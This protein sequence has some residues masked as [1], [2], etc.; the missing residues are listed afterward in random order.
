MHRQAT[1]IFFFP[2][3]IRIVESE[4]CQMIL[5]NIHKSKESWKSQ[6]DRWKDGGMVFNDPNLGNCCSMTYSNKPGQKNNIIHNKMETEGIT[7]T[8][9]YPY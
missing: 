3:A 9:E 7:R 6:I 8:T 4:C 1:N 2:W 5:K